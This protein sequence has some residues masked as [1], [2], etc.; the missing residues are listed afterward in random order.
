MFFFVATDHLLQHRLRHARPT[1]KAQPLP[2][3]AS[4]PLATMNAGTLQGTRYQLF[5]ALRAMA[6][7][8]AMVVERRIPSLAKHFE[9]DDEREAWFQDLRNPA[10]WEGQVAIEPVLVPGTAYPRVIGQIMLRAGWC[11]PSDEPHWVP[12]LRFFF[13]TEIGLRSF[14]SAQEWWSELTALE[15]VRLVFLE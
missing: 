10:N 8:E 2:R 7:G 11:A 1:G 6:G 5:R 15:R 13:L 14:R 4:T 3:P 12:N 9:R